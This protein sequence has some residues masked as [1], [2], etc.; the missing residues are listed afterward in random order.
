MSND[1]NDDL[2]DLND[3]EPVAVFAGDKSYNRCCRADESQMEFDPMY[4]GK[5]S[6]TFFQDHEIWSRNN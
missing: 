2:N 1:L 3:A 5:V 6:T 4:N